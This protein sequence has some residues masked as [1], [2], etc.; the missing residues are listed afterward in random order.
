MAKIT[1]IDSDAKKETSGKRSTGA[2]AVPPQGPSLFIVLI[3]A[4]TIALATWCHIQGVV[5]APDGLISD[6]MNS[7]PPSLRALGGLPS[8]FGQQWDE[9]LPRPY[10]RILLV[11]HVFFS[12]AF[13]TEIGVGIFA[14]LTS[15][16][17]PWVAAA[18]IEAAK[19][20]NPW[21]LSTLPIILVACAGQIVMIGVAF[22]AYY[23]PLAALFGWQQA[24]HSPQV[25]RPLP[26]PDRTQI[27]T[28]LGV[29]GASGLTIGALFLVPPDSGV[30]F[31]WASTSFQFF[32]LPWI[33]L[34][35][36]RRQRPGSRTREPRLAA[37][38]AYR[39]LAYGMIPLYWLG[40]YIALP[41]LWK[42]WQSG[43]GLPDD[44]A[45]L[46]W[47]DLIGITFGS[48]ALTLVQAE[49]DFRAVQCGGPRVHR[50]RLLIEDVVFGS[51]GVLLLGPGFATAM[52]HARREMLAEKARFGVETTFIVDRDESANG[53]D[54]PAQ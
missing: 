12:K 38:S 9:V 32:P 36:L 43:S 8:S 5:R 34:I 4:A 10:D 6:L 53:P 52:Y 47:Y 11:L 44:A 37:C 19:P 22:P 25:I 29:L 24:T 42:S 1:S 35:F 14:I 15:A 51:S 33:P 54:Q 41:D 23:V 45:V 31:F 7:D 3:P 28:I 26:S 49:I 13:S 46:A 27:F 20:G 39:L 50:A 2:P 18:L 17:I 21:L 16:A 48:Y 30:S 40:L